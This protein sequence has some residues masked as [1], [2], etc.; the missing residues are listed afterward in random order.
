PL[1]LFRPCVTAPIAL[2]SPRMPWAIEKFEA[3]SSAPATFRPVETR[4]WVTSSFRL[5]ELRLR[6][7]TKEPA[8]VLIEFCTAIVFILFLRVTSAFCRPERDFARSYCHQARFRI[9][10][11]AFYVKKSQMLATLKTAHDRLA[12]A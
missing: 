1:A 5:I 12:H 10:R 11:Q 2:S 9:C 3:S 8:L 4:F 7:A 6:R